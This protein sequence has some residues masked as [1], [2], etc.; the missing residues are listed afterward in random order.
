MKKGTVILLS[1]IALLGLSFTIEDSPLEK[2]IAQLKK[3][4][5]SY[6]QEKVHIQTDKP[7]YAVGEDIWFKAYVVTA[8]KNE[9]SLLSSV[10]YLDLVNEEDRMVKT[11]TVSIE[12]GSGNGNISLLD[13][14]PS[15]TYRLRA[16]TNYMRNYDA[17]FFFEKTIT[18]GNVLDKPNVPENARKLT[19]NAQFFPE[20][21]NLVNGIRSRVGIKVIKNDGLGMDLSGYVIN[22]KK[23]KVAL[24]STEYA[25][26]GAFALTPENGDEYTAVITLP[27]GSEKSVKL[28]E[29]IQ[30]G[31]T[32]GVNNIAGNLK[33][34]INC[35]PAMTN[36]KEM[37]LLA[38]VNGKV[39]SSL[40]FNASKPVFIASIPSKNFPT[41]IVQFT[42][43]NAERSAVAE[44]IA[45]VNHN[46]ALNI[47]I[48]NSVPGRTKQK[49]ILDISVKDAEG[50]PIDGNF[51]IS[52]TDMSKVSFTEDEDI[53]ILS[54]LL[55]TS[56]IKGFIER[57]NYY[58]NNID[59]KKIRH[60]DNLLLT[61]GWR[62]FSWKDIIANKEPEI[63]FR[64]EPS[65]E[66]TGNI[67]TLT[68]KPYPNA[69]IILLS[70]TKDF[71]LVL[72]TVSD[73][74]G[75][76]VFDRLDIPDSA[77]FIVQAK[78]QKDRKNMIVT[79]SER[80]KPS[81]RK[82]IEAPFN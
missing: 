47:N 35:S 22:K 36:G 67:R 40:R 59:E 39:F 64:A 56:D 62:R 58:F 26:M 25:G 7:Y 51:S 15:G 38:Q 27:D 63:T 42:L 4:T 77:V 29:A 20:G 81:A 80:P 65:L 14:I 11:H 43:L 19:V 54:N 60:L 55:L 21:G 44:R 28:P 75:N 16:Y 78:S 53:S 76:F 1:A 72:D 50:T 74:K 31:Y 49:A 30:E 66:I 45:F 73:A 46:D 71:P 10:L 9:P 82:I 6:P 69:R 32:L 33:V 52:V 61:Q 70:I 34:Q 13:T 23:E 3:Y 18:I 17:D 12:N 2:L 79:V 8:E 48:N 41:G 68:K 5:E 37:Y 57:P 24:F